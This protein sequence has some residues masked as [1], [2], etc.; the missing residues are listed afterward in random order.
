M[1]TIV[2][3]DAKI[4]AYEFAIEEDKETGEQ[5]TISI[6]LEDLDNP[7]LALRVLDSLTKKAW[8]TQQHIRQF[9]DVSQIHH[10]WAI[11]HIVD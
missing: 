7:L 6:P 1:K 5:L 4:K 2:R 10:R 9:F 11:W 3:F 8:F